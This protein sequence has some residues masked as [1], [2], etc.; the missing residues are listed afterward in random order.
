M[1]KNKYESVLIN[2]D[3]IDQESHRCNVLRFMAEKKTVSTADIADL[4]CIGTKSALQ[5][6]NALMSYEELCTITRQKSKVKHAPYEFTLEAIHM[7][8]SEFRSLKLSKAYQTRK[9]KVDKPKR[10]RGK[11]KK[12]EVIPRELSGLAMGNISYESRANGFRQGGKYV[13]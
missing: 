9:N 2:V 13:C 8:Y 5:H 1:M 3:M 6:L 7:K 10:I 11:S 4:L 12:S